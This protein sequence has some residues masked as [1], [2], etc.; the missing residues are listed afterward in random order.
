M[1]YRSKED[2]LLYSTRRGGDMRIFTVSLRH[3]RP[4]LYDFLEYICQFCSVAMYCT[5]LSQVMRDLA[6]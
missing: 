1:L 3:T 5:A 2:A 4:F 6:G